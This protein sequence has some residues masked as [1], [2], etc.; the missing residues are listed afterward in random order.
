M[1]ETAG[2]RRVETWRWWV[3]AIV[4]VV[5][6]ALE[7]P[8]AAQIP[9]APETYHV[10]VYYFPGWKDGAVGAPAPNPWDRLKAH[11]DREPLMGWYA[12]GEQAIMDQQLRWMADYGIAYVVFDQLFGRSGEVALEHALQAYLRSP[13]RNRVQFAVMWANHTRLP[14]SAD[15]F[16]RVVDTWIARYFKEPGYATL[17][18]KPVLFLFSIALLE[19]K[20]AAFGGSVQTLLEHAQD[21]AREAGLPGIAFVAGGAVEADALARARQA[22]FAAVSAYN[23]HNAPRRLRRPAAH[24]Y[25]ELAAGYR[26]NWERIAGASTLPLVVPLTSGWDKR[27]WGGSLDPRHDESMSRP[28]E[29][30]AHLREARAF[31]DRNRVLTQGQAVICCWNEYGE[32]S[33]VEP[34][35]R[36]GFA[37]LDRVRKVFGPCAGP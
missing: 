33:Y 22:G 4:A 1:Q 27:P 34:T 32:G 25:P 14:E 8:A 17:G 16:D 24:G 7:R 29:F 28:D 36:D 31:I 10:G 15:Q 3:G 2:E 37:F 5:C 11:P 30:E 9:P 23:Y 19:Q 21:K 12:E 35:K 13:E 18:G 6:A 26:E 20:V